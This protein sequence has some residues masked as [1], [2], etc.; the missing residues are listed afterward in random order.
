MEISHR[1]RKGGWTERER[2]RD[3]RRYNVVEEE[4]SNEEAMVRFPEKV[5]DLIF[6]LRSLS[7][8]W[9]YLQSR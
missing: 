7:S 8:C 3:N 4:E 5:L 6:P 2:E 9:V 1:G